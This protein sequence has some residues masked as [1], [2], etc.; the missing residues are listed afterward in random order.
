[1]IDYLIVFPNDPARSA[2]FPTPKES[3]YAPCWEALGGTAMPTRI[4]VADIV[5]S[6]DGEVA[7]PAVYGAGSWMAVRCDQRSPDIEAMPNCMIATSNDLAQAG[8]PYVYFC[9]LAS[10]TIMGRVDPVFAGDGYPFL[11]GQPASA[12]DAWMIDES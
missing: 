8:E 10:E 7:S 12:L 11:P 2:A 1:M 3:P 5:M 6:E 9:R 4:V